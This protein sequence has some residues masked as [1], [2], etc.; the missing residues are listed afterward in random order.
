M[1][2]KAVRFAVAVA[3]VWTIAGLICGLF[4]KAAPQAYARGANLLLHTDMYTS[5]R[6]LGWGELA[7]AIVVWWCLIAV[8]T[9][10]SVG[11]YNRSLRHAS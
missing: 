10:A 6:A 1:E 5:T 7:S 2:L 3:N 9:A 8:L 11:L 4:Y